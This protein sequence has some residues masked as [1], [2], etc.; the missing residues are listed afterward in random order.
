MGPLLTLLVW[1][2]VMEPTARLWT[3]LCTARLDSPSVGTEHLWRMSFAGVS[4]GLARGS[5]SPDLQFSQILTEPVTHL[6]KLE[7]I[8]GKRYRGR[9][10]P[11][12]VWDQSL[13]IPQCHLVTSLSSPAQL[14][15]T[16]TSQ[17]NC[18]PHSNL[19]SPSPCPRS[20][21]FYLHWV[22]CFSSVTYQTNH[23]NQTHLG[24]TGAL[25]WPLKGPIVTWMF[26]V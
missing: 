18:K 20:C 23:V 26:C 4:L 3:Q 19:D 21:P 17:A 6:P 25:W 13:L 12:R 14:D 10:D 22:R 15:S 5:R 9:V 24:A 11:S 2:I 1:G 16:H 8:C 7:L